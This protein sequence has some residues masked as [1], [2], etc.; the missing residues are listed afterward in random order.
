[1]LAE[2]RKDKEIAEKLLVK[3]VSNHENKIKEIQ[4]MQEANVVELKD[5][6]TA[7]IVD[8]ERKLEALQKKYDRETSQLTTRVGDLESTTRAQEDKIKRE[9]DQKTELILNLG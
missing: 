7:Q 3:E 6:F 4:V 9:A 2:F 5:K 8:L 1:M